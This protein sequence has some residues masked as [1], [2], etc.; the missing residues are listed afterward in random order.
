MSG[1]EDKQNID[2]SHF[3][4]ELENEITRRKLY[5]QLPPQGANM[6]EQRHKVMTLFG[7][8]HGM[9]EKDDFDEG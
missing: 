2:S 3:G 6:V 4:R 7:S 5:L 8:D 9:R 1:R